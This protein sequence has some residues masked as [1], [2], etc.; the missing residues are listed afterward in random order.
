MPK[1]EKHILNRQF[2]N[3]CIVLGIVF[4][5]RGMWGLMDL[6]LF[7]E[8]PTLSFTVSVLL[9]IFFLWAHDKRLK[10]LR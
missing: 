2:A 9:G 4:V 5:W 7:P 3:I 6:Y 10:D 8:Q 1:K